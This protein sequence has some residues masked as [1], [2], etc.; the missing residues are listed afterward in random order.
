MQ[1]KINKLYIDVDKISFLEIDESRV[2]AIVDGVHLFWS[3]EHY[4]QEYL[5]FI[6]KELCKKV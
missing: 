5:E 1:E 4:S 2:E 6:K 3:D